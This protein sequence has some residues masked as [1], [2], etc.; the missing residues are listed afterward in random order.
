MDVYEIEDEE[1]SRK[2]G[3]TVDVGKWSDTGE[4]ARQVFQLRP[5]TAASGNVSKN[6]TGK[7]SKTMPF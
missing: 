5:S 6:V 7:P 3:T 2:T 1:D 4:R